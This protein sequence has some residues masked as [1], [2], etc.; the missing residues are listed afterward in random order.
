M[1]D[2]R[3]CRHC[4]TTENVTRHHLLK[5]RS[6]QAL[7]DNRVILLCRSFHERLHKGFPTEREVAYAELRAVL[8]DDERA[9]LDRKP[10]PEL[11]ELRLRMGAAPCSET[12][13]P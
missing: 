11:W 13:E 1:N 9:L 2:D 5:R 6:A 12:D 8:T 7:G 10:F 4:G 3:V